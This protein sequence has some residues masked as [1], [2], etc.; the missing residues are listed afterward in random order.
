MVLIHGLAD[1]HRGWRRA[2]PRLM[3]DYR[4]ILYDFRGHG[5]SSLGQPDGRLA[6][7]AGDLAALLDAL[8]LERPSLAGFSLGGTIA[9]RFAIDY[10]DRLDRLMPVATSSRVGRAAAEWYVER[11]GLAD[12]GAD[13]LLPHLEEDTREQFKTAPELAA[14]HM[15]IRRQSVADPR[16]YANACRAM[17]RLREE[18]LD[19]ELAQIKAPTLVIAGAE[20]H[21]CPPK[22]GEMIAAGIEGA[23]MEVIPDCGHQIP[24]QEPDRLAKLML[25]FLA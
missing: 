20:D 22:A 2:L 18:P 16:G 4:V 15:R 10:P 5:A 6:Q 8:E 17:T 14:E 7:L 13:A 9:M 25:E 21:L 3:L 24:A 19:P 23:R 12:K 11:A 1:D